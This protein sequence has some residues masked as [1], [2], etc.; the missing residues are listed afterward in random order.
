MIGPLVNIS[1]KSYIIEE[2]KDSYYYDFTTILSEIGGS[3][4]ILVGVSC[5]T[6]FKF[7]IYVQTR[8][9]SLHQRYHHGQILNRHK[10]NPK[11]IVDMVKNEGRNSNITKNQIDIINKV[12]ECGGKKQIIPKKH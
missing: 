1:F 12:N 10:F 3:L 11:K 8:I 9:T 4:G 2:I 5:M 7:C 6:I